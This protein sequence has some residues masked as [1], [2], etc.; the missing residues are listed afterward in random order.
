MKAVTRQRPKNANYSVSSNST[1]TNGA[2]LKAKSRVRQPPKQSQQLK[3]QEKNFVESDGGKMTKF[4]SLDDIPDFGEDFGNDKSKLDVGEPSCRYHPPKSL[5]NDNSG[6]YQNFIED[7]DDYITEKVHQKLDNPRPIKEPPPLPAEK[8]CSLSYGD[9][10]CNKQPKLPSPQNVISYDHTNDDQ[11]SN[12]SDIS[13]IEDDDDCNRSYFS[14]TD[15]Y[16]IGYPPSQFCHGRNK[17]IP[18]KGR[19][20]RSAKPIQGS[21]PTKQS[22]CDIQEANNMR[23][24][25][26]KKEISYKPYTLQQYRKINPK[27][28]VEFGKLKPDLNTADLVAKRANAER[29]KQFSKNLNDFN[30][31]NIINNVISTGE[32]ETRKPAKILSKREKA[33]QFAQN[34]PKPKLKVDKATLHTDDSKTC[35]NI[36]V[37]TC[38]TSRIDEL[39]SRHMQ[40]K[41]QVEAI[42][43]SMG[44]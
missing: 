15:D 17:D 14:S 18:A 20:I 11:I 8:L 39:T 19:V 21:Y 28:Y 34:V 5:N 24:T 31:K 40:S 9:A 44:L 25:T 35:R 37:E 13:D 26:E 32:R 38:P 2:P 22:S 10:R 6:Y 1:M 16:H 30:R 29:I 23:I 27:D 43:K 3:K 36:G 33:L 12:E 41:K 42:K 4:R 7:P